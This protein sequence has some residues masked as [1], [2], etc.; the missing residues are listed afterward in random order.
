[1]LSI[2]DLSKATEVF[3]L[4]AQKSVDKTKLVVS[5]KPLTETT[6]TVVMSNGNE[7]ARLIVES[8]PKIMQSF[9][10]G[11]NDFLRLFKIFNDRFNVS[12]DN[13]KICFKKNKNSYSCVETKSQLNDSVN[14]KFDFDG[15]YKI[16]IDKPLILK[17]IAFGGVYAIADNEIAST[18]GFIGVIDKIDANT[19]GNVFLFRDEFPNGTYFY[20]PNSNLIVSEDKK[21]CCTMRQAVNKFPYKTF[22][23]LVQSNLNNY[24]ICDYKEFYEHI[25]QCVDINKEHV[26]IYLNN[27][28]IRISSVDKNS[29]CHYEVEI[30]V[31]YKTQPKRK[32]IRFNPN[33]MLTLTKA[34]EDDKIKIEFDD[35]ER[36]RIIRA[37]STKHVIFGAEQV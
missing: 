30:Q 10:I 6:Y 7:S 12:V 29:T 21:L 11:Y 9:D 15:S 4:I 25:R 16:T 1:M 8:E 27:D 33:Y 26:I 3:N 28:T 19:K 5:F 20:N 35:D 24:F 2:K 13:G 32:M 34:N 14:F 36:I 17:T 37:K 31:Q 23:R 22:S 18:D